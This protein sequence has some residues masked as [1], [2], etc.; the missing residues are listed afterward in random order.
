MNLI[1]DIGVNTGEFTD[2]C[3][4]KYPDAVIVGAE[5]NPILFNM[6]QEK[7]KNQ[8]RVVLIDRVI[9]RVN[10]ANILFH[11]ADMNN[12]GVS[13]ASLEF[14]SK[15]RF[16]KGSKNLPEGSVRWNPISKL[17]TTLDSL[18]RTHG[19]P[20][21]I[22]IDTEGFEYQV[23]LGLSRKVGEITFEWHEEMYVEAIKCIDHLTSLGYTE[24][25]NIGYFDGPCGPFTHSESGDPYLEKP[26]NYMDDDTLVTEM[27]KIVNES[28]RVS[29]GMLFAR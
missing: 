13:T 17:T 5:A 24:F 21:L 9:S 16:S 20:D 22:K 4:Q 12:H 25:G 26:E 15:S 11:V 29:Y 2:K 14:I 28:R 8:P 10:N 7:Y 6:L 23:L 1:F 19:E 27:N 3:L 18:I